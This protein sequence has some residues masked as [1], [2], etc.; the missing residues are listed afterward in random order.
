MD[1]I[2]LAMNIVTLVQILQQTYETLKDAPAA[3][4]Q[5][6]AQANSLA[7]LLKRLDSIEPFL[8]TDRKQFLASQFDHAACAS[9]VK[10]LRTLVDKINPYED[11]AEKSGFKMHLLGGLMLKQRVMWFLKES[12]VM[13]L[14]ERMKVQCGQIANAT[15][16]ILLS[17]ALPLCLPLANL[18]RECGLFMEKQLIEL[19]EAMLQ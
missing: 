2:G 14:S 16:Q 3:L 17:E 10:D 15:D 18:C 6:I 12:S 4:E 1:G 19:R 7:V 8:S 9:T 5:V 13:K 11:G